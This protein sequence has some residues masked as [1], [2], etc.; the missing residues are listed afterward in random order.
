M[1]AAVVWALAIIFFKKS[2]ESVHPIG[3]NLFKN[4]V[5]LVLF[6]PTLYLWDE[7][8]FRQAPARDYLLLILS[9]AIGIG[10]AD[11]LFFKSLNILGAGLSAIVDCLYSPFVIFLSIIFLGEKL[12]V[13]QIAGSLLIISAVLAITRVKTGPALTSN[14]LVRGICYGALAMALMAAGIVI[15]KPILNRSP[16]LWVIQIR[17][18]GG[19]VILSLLLPF[20]TQSRSILASLWD[21]KK[22]KYT[23]T[24]SFLGTYIAMLLWL[25]GMKLTLASVASALNQTSNIF[26]FIFAAVI[27]K[28][29]MNKKKIVAIILAMTGAFMVMFY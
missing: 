28:E 12:T 1:L 21:R 6:I 14:Q 19:A 20:Y 11:T 4:T 15:A 27:L 25:A 18:I 17:I 29:S 23:V 10:V 3:L 13:Y 7:T 16:L 5:A 24:G 2:G 8:L 9:G 26:V 22:W